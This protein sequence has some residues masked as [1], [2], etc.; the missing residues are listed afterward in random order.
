MN[1]GCASVRLDPSSFPH[2]YVCKS[3]T[4]RTDRHL[5]FSFRRQS[6]RVREDWRINNFSAAS[7]HSAKSSSSSN[8]VVC[9]AKAGRNYAG[10]ARRRERRH[11]RSRRVQQ[12]AAGATGRF[13][14]FSSRA[15][16]RTPSAI[17]GVVT[18]RS[19]SWPTHWSQ[20]L[21]LP[22]PPSSQLPQQQQQQPVNNW[23]R[24]FYVVRDDNRT[25]LLRYDILEYATTNEKQKCRPNMVF[26]ETIFF[27]SSKGYSLPLLSKF[28]YLI[29]IIINPF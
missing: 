20:H 18:S 29:S 3:Q 9:M 19:S 27:Y 6:C 4:N 23:F 15:S 24:N 2:D 12:K 25:S 16:R 8:V 10:Q 21:L 26:Y 22:T 28:Y 1:R 17:S 11:H 14:A 5:L 7:T 13:V